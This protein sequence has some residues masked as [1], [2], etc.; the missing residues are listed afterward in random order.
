MTGRRETSKETR[1]KRIIDAAREHFRDRGFEA[2]TIEAIAETAGVSAVTVYNHYRTKG[3]VLLALVT[4]SDELL[5][6]KIE[7]LIANP[8]TDPLDGVC[9]FSATINEHAF[10]YLNREIWRHVIASSII[11]GDSDFG[12]VY[13]Q[14]DLE[15]IKLLGTFLDSL[16]KR[17]LTIKDCDCSAAAEVFYNLHNARFLEFIIDHNR[18]V[19]QR[20]ALTRR[21]LSF[22]MGSLREQ[23]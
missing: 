1:R 22:V 15:L 2:A 11:E 13:R 14:L 16:R 17:K 12:R 3:G 8:P 18:T 21:D 10:S 20:E 7:R 6:E 9:A 23:D 5:I 19:E 4:A